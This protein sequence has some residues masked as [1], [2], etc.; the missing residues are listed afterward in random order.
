V[1]VARAAG[2]VDDLGHGDAV[3]AALGEAVVDGGET[4]GKLCKRGRAML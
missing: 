4:V 2:R 3:A 1:H